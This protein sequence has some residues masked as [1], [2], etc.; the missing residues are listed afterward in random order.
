MRFVVIAAARTGSTHLVTQ[1]NREPDIWC[2]D[3]VFHPSRVFLRW[4][5]NPPASVR[6]DL[7][8]ELLAL[9]E[10]DPDRFLARVHGLGFDRRNVGMRIF[11]RHDPAM[12]ARM[13]A[14]PEIAKIVLLRANVL[15]NYASRL[16]A[17]DDGAWG[18][19]DQEQRA[20]APPVRF[21]RK[22]FITHHDRYLGFFARTLERLNASG[23]P[24]RLIRYDE[25]NNPTLLA[26]LAQFLG[27]RSA[28]RPPPVTRHVRGHSDILS[29]FSNPAAAKHFL[30]SIGHP[31]WAH[32]GEVSFAPLAAPSPD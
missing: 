18:V 24:Y 9:R 30:K 6:E 4:P 11:E 19:V 32:E 16:E 22:A 27:A 17:R 20:A 5:G 14:D 21:G 10:S 7:E 1:L 8:A 12:L 23:Q 29:R 26:G 15:A 13:I 3:E 2:H 31:E 25:L 28:P